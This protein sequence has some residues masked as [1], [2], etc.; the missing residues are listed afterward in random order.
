MKPGDNFSERFNETVTDPL[1]IDEIAG[2]VCCST[3]SP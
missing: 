3:W 2:D 1:I